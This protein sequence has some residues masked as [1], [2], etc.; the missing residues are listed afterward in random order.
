[1]PNIWHLWHLCFILLP[2]RSSLYL[3]N[4]KY[5]ALLF[6]FLTS[7]KLDSNL[8]TEHVA[9]Y[10][11]LNAWPCWRFWLIIINIWTQMD[12]CI[13]RPTRCTNT[14]NVSLF[15][16]KFS[17]CFGRLVHHQEQ[18]FEA[19]YHNWYK[20]VPYVWLLCGYSHTTA[21]HVS[22][23]TGLYQ[24]WYTARKLCSWWWTK[25]SETC[26]ELNDK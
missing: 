4:A 9:F 15:I 19:V 18:C 2:V 8:K 17:T 3:P 6:Y 16:I 13:S 11:K 10:A 24:L 14:C 7:K 22:A 26:T 12:V 21:T 1:M 25:Q 5:L 20:P 23:Y